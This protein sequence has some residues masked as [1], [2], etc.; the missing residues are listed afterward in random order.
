LLERT[1]EHCPIAPLASPPL[2]VFVF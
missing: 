1:S 2:P